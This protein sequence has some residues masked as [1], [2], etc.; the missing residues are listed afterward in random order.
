MKFAEMKGWHNHKDMGINIAHGAK[1]YRTPEPR[2][3]SAVCPLRTTFGRFERPS[4]EV[5][6]RVLER[7]NRYLQEA[8][9]HQLLEQPTPVLVTCFAKET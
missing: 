2:F 8:N 6:W 4:G 5:C 1:S 9:Q 7:N 3:S